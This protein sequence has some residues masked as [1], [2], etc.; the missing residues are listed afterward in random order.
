MFD[1]IKKRFQTFTNR[2][3]KEM[4]DLE[5]NL[6][7]MDAPSENENDAATV[8]SELIDV[9]WEQIE[10]IYKATEIARQLE[11]K[12]AQACVQL[13]RTKAQLLQQ[14]TEVEAYA[15]QVGTQLKE[16]LNIDPNLVYE[17][18]LPS[19]VGQKA[20]FMRKDQ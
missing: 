1:K 16:S 14:M 4:E 3:E 13:E 2:K 9:E 20:F 11:V 15:I 8:T 6:A 5:V 10:P 7:G 17:L 12:L 18:K 19:E